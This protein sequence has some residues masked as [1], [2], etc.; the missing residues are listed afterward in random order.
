MK[1]AATNEKP[2]RKKIQR[3]RRPHPLN[4]QKT[5][6]PKEQHK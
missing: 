5:L 3:R 6:G 2:W 4:H 1:K